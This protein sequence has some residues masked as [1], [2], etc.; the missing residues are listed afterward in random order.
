[1]DALSD[2]GLDSEGSPAADVAD[3]GGG[4][5]G[6]DLHSELA[7]LAVNDFGASLDA[8]SDAI[9]EGD[10]DNGVEASKSCI[11]APLC[12]TRYGLGGRPR[13]P[14]LRWCQ[15][16]RPPDKKR[17]KHF[18]QKL[19]RQEQTKKGKKGQGRKTIRENDKGR[20]RT[21]IRKERRR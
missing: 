5:D 9:V 17:M 15:E 7:S 16:L 3:V 8:L 11:D 6:D 20:Q 19:R 1:M 14:W 13:M 21:K 2:V 12:R 10:D 18:R 4:V